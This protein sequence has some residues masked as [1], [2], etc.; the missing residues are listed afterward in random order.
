MQRMRRNGRALMTLAIS[1]MFAV[2]CSSNGTTTQPSSTSTP[3]PT[4]PVTAAAP[5]PCVMSSSFFQ[6]PNIVSGAGGQ[7]F[8]GFTFLPPAGATSCTT[9][10]VTAVSNAP[11]I[12]AGPVLS[13]PNTVSYNHLVTLTV[14][15]N[16]ASAPRSG[17][18]TI[19]D[20][21]ATI[22]QERG[23]LIVSLSLFDPARTSAA[24]TECYIRGPLSQ[25]TTC[26]VQVSITA[27][28]GPAVVSYA[29]DVEIPITTLPRFTQTGGSSQMSFSA[30]CGQAT[31]TPDGR[32]DLLWVSLTVTDSA[33]NSVHVPDPQ[34]QARLFSCGS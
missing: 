23:Q 13:T 1:A 5:P 14:A 19:A 24:T 18:V 10:S 11:F 28:G 9:P 12:T 22:N 3:A 27:S 29:W 15:P 17:T 21:T 16:E 25:P 31:S 2:A 33:G 34:F 30:P 32:D 6:T 7:A 4:T 8:V 26:I 20:R